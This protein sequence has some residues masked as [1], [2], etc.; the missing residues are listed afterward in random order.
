MLALL[1]SAT[2]TAW[3]TGLAAALGTHVLAAADPEG[4]AVLGV[5]GAGAAAG[6][7]AEAAHATLGEILR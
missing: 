6:L 3:R 7:P 5:I 4:G 1:D 2:I